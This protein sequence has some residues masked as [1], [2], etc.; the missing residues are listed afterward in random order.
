MRMSATIIF[1]IKNCDTMKKTFNWFVT[2]NIPF[3]FH[4]YKKQG[5]DIDVLSSAIKQHGWENV[6]NRRGTTWRK[7]SDDI[8]NPMD[9]ASAI[10][11]AE[12]NASIVKRPLTKKGS[13]I[14]LGFNQDVYEKTFKD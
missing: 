6:I 5:V 2:E 11:I 8:K 10:K 9:Y 13:I 7:L 3:I 1:G 14:T 12:D 4:D